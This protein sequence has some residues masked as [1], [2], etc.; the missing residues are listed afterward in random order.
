M[1]SKLG[2]EST[3]QDAAEI[4][5]LMGL[6]GTPSSTTDHG[7]L[8]GLGDDDHAQYMHISAARTITAQH[9]FSPSVTQA[10]FVLG[11]NAQGQLVAGLNADLL[12]GFE[13]SDFATDDPLF[14][15]LAV[16][17][18]LNNERVFTPGN[19][20]EATDGGAGSTYTLAVD[21]SATSGLEFSSGELQIADTIAGNGLGIATKVLAVGAGDGITVS[22][23]AV[24][25]TTPGT[26]SVSSSNSSAGSHTHA[27][28]SSSNPGAATSL[29]KSDTS[30]YLQLIRLGLGVAPS[31]PLHIIET[32]QQARIGYDTNNYL[33]V[34]VVSSG[35]VTL[36]T[37]T[38]GTGG[39]LTLDTA[40]DI[41]VD[42][43]GNNVRP[44]TAYDVNLGT[45]LKK[46]LSLYAAELNVETLVAQD[47]MATIGGRVLVAPTTFLTADIL[48]TDTT[49][50]TKHNNLAVDDIVRMEAG[51]FVEFMQID[52][53]PTDSA[54]LGLNMGFESLS[55]IGGIWATWVDVAG[56]GTIAADSTIRHSGAY[57]CKITAGASDNTYVY[58]DITVLASTKYLFSFFAYS[59][60][61]VRV[62]DNS[63]SADII[64]RLYQAIGSS[65]WERGQTFFTTPIGCTSI[66]IYL[67]CRPSLMTPAPMYYDDIHLGLAQYSYTV[68]RNLD[69]TG[70]NDWAS[71][72][73]IVNLGNTGDGW[74]DLY[75]TWGMRDHTQVG[76]T[77]AGSVRNSLTFNDWSET[78]AIGN[79]HGLYDYGADAFGAAFGKY[80]DSNAWVSVDS[81]NGF[82]IM[83]RA[84]S[85]DTQLGQ[86]SAAGVITIGETGTGKSNIYISSGTLQLRLNVTPTITLSTVGVV[87]IGAASSP[88]VVI[89]SGGME[90]LT[91]GGSTLLDI[92]ATN[93]DIFIGVPQ[94]VKLSEYGLRIMRTVAGT[95]GRL[96][97]AEDLTGDTTGFFSI[98]GYPVA[99]GEYGALITMPDFAGATGNYN[100]MSV[101]AEAPT[102]STGMNAQLL[103][104]AHYTGS[105]SYMKMLL[106]GAE[107]ISITSTGLVI[108]EGGGNYDFRIES[109]TNANAL[110]IDGSLGIMGIGGAVESG[111]ELKVTG[112]FWATASGR[113]GTQ[114]FINET[115]NSFMDYGLT[116]NVGAGA[117]EGFAL[118]ASG[119]ATGFTGITETDTLGRLA[120]W[121]TDYG[122]MVVDGLSEDTG[123]LLLRGLAVVDVTAKSTSA[124]AY[125]EVRAHK[126]SGSSAGDI[127]TN[128]NIIAFRNG[129]TTRQILDGDGD[130]HQD[131]GTL[132]TNF[133]EHDDIDLLNMMS[134]HLTREDDP[135]RI[136]FNK[137]LEKNREPLEEMKLVTFNP[138]GHHFINWSRTNML[139]IGAAIQLSKRIERL[140]S[141][142]QALLPPGI[143]T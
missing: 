90:F 50:Y 135:L 32:T 25:L 127:G 24:A 117:A 79:L 21:L 34:T 82:R 16:D 65:S 88:Q 139:I 27:V 71:G 95:T 126:L 52:T 22:A 108:N 47:V 85:T 76:P 55:G 143:V 61:R 91:A 49:I 56:D 9:S 110:V 53:G 142:L 132:W 77:I 131:V 15:T 121:S 96:M 7:T 31:Y 119:I 97:F 60:A 125:I 106:G 6:S 89:D 99:S 72:D 40:G 130:S 115:S 111:W 8:L 73:A 37:A 46:Y 44:A 3:E 48:S 57:S 54:E 23:N 4:R 45:P 86:W 138:D 93:S 83:K 20:L 36:A 14:L 11:A 129:T 69:G 10:P 101:L 5:V 120:R 104:L 134:A 103:M 38:S 35:S 116:I 42:P 28:T 102:G 122:G 66:R 133:S 13:A 100:Q 87:T 18:T 68:T 109:D 67:Y 98:Q 107:R 19:G 114:F 81:T 64:P 92:D 29:L 33:A 1:T 105:S 63:N 74:I 80:S 59:G 123:G 17:G 84:S 58:Q 62:Y 70:A 51:G 112:D 137:W 41:I 136:Y 2:R 141:H 75:A 26:L 128:A 78:W 118:K 113:I 124:G 94:R 12:D 43:E 30:G 39:N 140:E